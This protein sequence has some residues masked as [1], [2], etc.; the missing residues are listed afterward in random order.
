[1]KP[2]KRIHNAVLS[3]LA[4]AGLIAFAGGCEIAD[5]FTRDRTEIAVSGTTLDAAAPLPEVRVE[6][7]EMRDGRKN[8]T[9]E[10]TISDESGYFSLTGRVTCRD[11]TGYRVFASRRNETDWTLRTASAAVECS[12]EPQSVSLALQ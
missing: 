10:Q 9:L 4:F 7:Q 2:D 1:M 8:G 12:D 5:I 11:D 3:A 6:L